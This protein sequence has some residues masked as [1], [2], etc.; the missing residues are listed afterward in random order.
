MNSMNNQPP[1]KTNV[2]TT[3]NMVVGTAPIYKNNVTSYMKTELQREINSFI[4]SGGAK[5]G[6]ANLDKIIGSL[7]PGFYVLGAGSSLGKT[8]FLLQMADQLIADCEPVIYFTMEQ[9]Q[10]ELVTKSLSRRTAL[11]CRASPQHAKTAIQIRKG[12]ISQEVLDAYQDYLQDTDIFTI[13]QGDFSTNMDEIYRIVGDYVATTGQVPI[14]MIDYLQIIQEDQATDKA[15]VDYITKK[16][17]VLQRTYNTVVIA[18]SSIN[19]GNYMLPI[20]FE[21][22]KESGSIEYSA[23]CVWG[24]QLQ[25]LNDP[26]FTQAKNQSQ[27]R[28]LMAMAKAA[29][30]RQV[31]LVCLKNRYGIATYSC[32]FLYYAQ[33]DLFTVDPNYKTATLVCPTPKI[34]I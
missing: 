26:A 5:T 34:I 31:E 28:K 11:K 32:G 4:T 1:P 15:K 21:S 29:S 17:K 27:R 10:L 20:D 24:L 25:I 18:I 12:E 23:D 3:P 2:I 9:S 8:T 22:F 30:P 16:L 13:V 7:Y 14:I 33:Y 19:R 6:Y